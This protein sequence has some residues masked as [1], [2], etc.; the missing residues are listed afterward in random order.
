MRREGRQ[1]GWVFA[2]DRSLVDPE[3]KIRARAVQVDG[4]A[5]ANGGFVRAP[6]KPTNHS[7]PTV[8]RAYKALIGKG[9]AAGSGR[10]RHKFKYDEVKLYYQEADGAADAM[11]DFDY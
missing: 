11:L 7:K 9:E 2:V 3:G 4:T 1:R 10:G 6:R 5:A 8:G